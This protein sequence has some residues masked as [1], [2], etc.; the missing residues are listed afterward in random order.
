M[1]LELFL[2]LL[3]GVGGLVAHELGHV[4]AYRVLRPD[5]RWS[6][7]LRGPALAVEIETEVVGLRRCVVATAGP[8]LGAIFVLV[9][10]QAAAGGSVSHLFVSLHLAMLVPIFADGRQFVLGVREMVPLTD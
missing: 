8:T 3:M 10:S 6:V 9:V 5:G 1:L 2:I 7:E 4:F